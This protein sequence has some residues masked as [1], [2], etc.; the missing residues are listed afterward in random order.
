MT[1]WYRCAQ[2]T[3]TP[4]S[5]L[6]AQ[7]LWSMLPMPAC[8][9]DL[10]P[11]GALWPMWPGLSAAFASSCFWHCP[12]PSSR[13]S[14]SCWPS[15]TSPC[16]PGQSYHF[17]WS[18]VW[19]KMLCETP[20]VFS[21]GGD[22]GGRRIVAVVTSEA[23]HWV[24][25][26]VSNQLWYRVDSAG[27]GSVRQSNPFHDQSARRTLCFLALTRTFCQQSLKVTSSNQ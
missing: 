2:P 11:A 4:M 10:S 3:E 23:H 24:T 15:A 25:Y 12:P 22:F 26:I 9:C 5:H 8:L 14:R 18:H 7:S 20:A 1:S 13:N 6:L 21:C 16:C 19:Q 27:G 17:D